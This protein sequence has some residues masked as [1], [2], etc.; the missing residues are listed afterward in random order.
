VVWKS[1]NYVIIAS[2]TVGLP[3]VPQGAHEQQRGRRRGAGRGAESR[4]ERA[5]HQTGGAAR[6]RCSLALLVGVNGKALQGS[7]QGSLQESLKDAEFIT[8]EMNG[9]KFNKLVH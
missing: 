6:W 5:A 9:E 3:R 4:V 2:M 1:K 8:F 7:L